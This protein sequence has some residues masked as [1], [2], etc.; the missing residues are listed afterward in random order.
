MDYLE[1]DILWNI[2][3]NEIFV[4]VISDCVSV[5]FI[6]IGYKRQ[7]WSRKIQKYLGVELELQVKVLAT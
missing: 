6:I 5:Y 3:F 4:K 7:Y 2:F 1:R